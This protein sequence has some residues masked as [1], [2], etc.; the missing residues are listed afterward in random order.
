MGPFIFYR[1]K[2]GKRALH[3]VVSKIFKGVLCRLL[4]SFEVC[5]QRN[6]NKKREIIIGHAKLMYFRNIIMY[7]IELQQNL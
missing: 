5:L 6:L 7:N 3:N 2:V 4:K 1:T